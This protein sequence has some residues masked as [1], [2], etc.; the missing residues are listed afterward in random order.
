MCCEDLIIFGCCLFNYVFGEYLVNEI[1]LENIS[2]VLSDLKIV[3]MDDLLVVIGLGELMSIVIVCCLFGNVDELIEF[4]KFGGNK[5][6]LLICGVEGI[7]F[8]F[9]NCCY[10]IFDDYIIVYVLLGCGLVVYCE[11]CL[12]VC[13][14]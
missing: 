4:S 6:K 3:L 9:V 12:N 8:I 11:I 10:F 7:L 2:K 13:G 14:Y 5:N 1:V